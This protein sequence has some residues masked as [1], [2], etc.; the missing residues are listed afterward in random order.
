MDVYDA[1]LAIDP[2]QAKRMVFVTGGAFTPRA[3]E[4]L[5]RVGNPRAEKPLDRAALRALVRAQLGK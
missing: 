3:A 4:F 2:L 5:E 1:V